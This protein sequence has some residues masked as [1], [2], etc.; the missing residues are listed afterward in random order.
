MDKLGKFQLMVME[1]LWQAESPQT[2]SRLSQ[3]SSV[4]GIHEQL[5]KLIKMGYVREA[6]DVRVAKT[7]SKL[8]SPTITVQDYEAQLV[9]EVAGRRNTRI[10][11]LVGALLKKPGIHSKED[12]E[13]LENII[14]SF[15]KD[16]NP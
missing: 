5:A 14:A 16:E 7:S 4:K 9:Q 10:P 13:L 3:L 6:G 1:A 11:F 8:Y 12:L 15:K 2:A